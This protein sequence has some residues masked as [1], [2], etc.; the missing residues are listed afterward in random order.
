MLKMVRNNGEVPKRVHDD[1]EAVVGLLMLSNTHDKLFGGID[2][3]RHYVDEHLK[4]FKEERQANEPQT[5]QQPE[6]LSTKPKLTYFNPNKRLISPAITGTKRKSRNSIQSPNNLMF[7]TQ[8]N[9]TQQIAAPISQLI[10]HS[11]SSPPI[12]HEPHSPS[13]SGHSSLI[14][15]HN[16]LPAPV[17]PQWTQTPRFGLNPAV[18]MEFDKIERESVHM[19][20]NFTRQKMEEC[21]ID[22]EYNPNKSRLRKQYNDPAQAEDR[23]RNNLASRRSRY[24]KKIAAQLLSLNLDFEKEENRKLFKQE[25]WMTTIIAEL[26][27]KLLQRGF[28]PVVIKNLRFKCG[29]K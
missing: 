11:Y 20:E 2:N 12:K 4:Y 8:I 28:E 29:F 24:K 27:E 9:S 23:A 13:D 19:K 6:D 10:E 17:L 18:L 21:P 25:T 22:Y 5:S 26:E 14:D 3:F 1:V 15:E 7:T 16:F